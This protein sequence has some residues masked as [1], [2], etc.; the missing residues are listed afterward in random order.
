MIHALLTTP[1]GWLVLFGLLD[2]AI[3]F[4]AMVVEDIRLPKWRC[5]HWV[6]VLVSYALIVWVAIRVDAWQ[7][8]RPPAA[9]R[10]DR[11]H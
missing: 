7:H 5:R 1:E 2:G 6:P 4:G 8:V 11:P 10:K 3:L 9:M